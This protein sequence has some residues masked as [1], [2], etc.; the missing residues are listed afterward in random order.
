MNNCRVKTVLVSLILPSL[1]PSQSFL[2]TSPLQQTKTTPKRV[3]VENK[4]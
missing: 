4:Y 2:K 3:T 1:T